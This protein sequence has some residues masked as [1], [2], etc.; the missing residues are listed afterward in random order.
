M[1]AGGHPDHEGSIM[2]RRI[3]STIQALALPVCVACVLAACGGA[4]HGDGL[5]DAQ[6]EDQAASASTAGLLDFGN[7]QIARN[8]SDAAEPRSIAA[9]TPPLDETGEPPPL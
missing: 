3:S 2:K 6:R 5:T 9:I 8:S 4:S 1:A 7:G